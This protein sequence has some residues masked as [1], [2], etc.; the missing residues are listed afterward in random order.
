MT[1]KSDA[2]ETLERLQIPL[3]G[4]FHALRWDK[5][6][7]L[8]KEAKRVKYRRPKDAFGSMARYFHDLLQ[9]RAS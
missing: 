1:S 9:R 8:L 6:T 7:A 2:R 3:G 4:D 5:I